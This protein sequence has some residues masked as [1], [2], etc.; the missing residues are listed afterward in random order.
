MAINYNFSADPNAVPNNRAIPSFVDALT[1]GYQMSQMPKQIKMQNQLTQAQI[2]QLKSLTALRQTQAQ[3]SMNPEAKLTGDIGNAY[4]LEMLRQQA[5]TDP[6]K[7]QYYNAAKEASD[8]DRQI[9]NALMD[10]RSIMG[11]TAPQRYASPLGKM[12][13][14]NY[15]VGQGYLPGTN[16]SVNLNPSQQNTLQNQYGLSQLKNTTDPGI[17]QKNL[18]IQNIDKTLSTIDPSV[19]TQYSGLSGGISKSAQSVASQFGAESKGY[20]EYLKNVISA[21][22][23]AKQM[24]QFLGDSIQASA[25]KQLDDLTNPETW[26][27]NPAQAKAQFQRFIELYNSEKNNYAE[28]LRSPNVYYRSDYSASNQKSPDLSRYSTDDLKRIAGIK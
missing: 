3:Q 1:K 12:A 5:Q 21:T 26:K 22:V 16:N 4:N 9:Q 15:Y 19:L 23:A 13:Y 27:V 7:M 17:R 10:Y 18:Y 20:D 28:A 6:S 8:R 24:R 2:D 25:Q 11:Q 14:E